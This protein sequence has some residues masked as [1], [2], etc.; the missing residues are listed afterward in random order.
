MCGIAGIY[1]FNQEAT[2]KQSLL[3]SM[4]HSL[5]HRGPDSRGIFT[6]GAFGFGMTRLKII[7]LETGN[8]PI[9]NDDKSVG[10]IFNGEI[11]NFREIKKELESHGYSF[12][13]KSDT[14]LILRAYEAYGLKCLDYF[15]GMFAVAIWN[16]HEKKLFL[17]RDRVGQKPLYYYQDRHR[18]IFASEIK[19]ILCCPDVEREIDLVALDDYLN[20]GYIPGQRTIYKHIRKLQPAHWA[21]LD[22][23][24]KLT[25]N[26]YWEFPKPKAG[27]HSSVEANIEELAC[28]LEDAVRIRLISDVPLG[29]FLS[30]GLDSSTIVS[31][32]S[33]LMPQSAKTFHIGFFE[34][35]FDES[36]Y[37][38]HVASLFNTEHHEDK[39]SCDLGDT[40]EH[41]IKCFDEPF[42]DSSAIP[43]YYLAQMASKEVT[44][45]LS[46]D[47]GDEIFGG[48]SRYIG[49]RWVKMYLKMPSL[50]RNSVNKIM[51]QI[52]EGT[53][54]RPVSLL[55]QVKWLIRTA[56]RKR[57]N[58][59]DMSIGI[60]HDHE[61]KKILHPC[62]QNAL[63]Q[64]KGAEYLS[65][66]DKIASNYGDGDVISQMMW[67]DAQTYLVDNILVKVDRMSM[68][69]SLEVRNPLLDHR[70][71]EFMAEVPV[72]LKVRGTKTKYLIKR[73][74]Q[75]ILPD[76][77]I[78][79]KKYGFSAPL[80]KWF[81]G[82]LRSMVSDLLLQNH[83]S[84]WLDAESVRS[85]VKHHFE[86]RYDYSSQIWT[87]LVLTL[88]ERNSR[89]HSRQ[90]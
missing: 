56:E 16:L 64:N 73:Y 28:L 15:Q 67:V 6:E 83:G 34:E 30:G 41:I 44:V 85:I 36:R 68:A 54:N 84:S 75:S 11:Y 31:V 29:A 79:R 69:H 47:G 42:A 80:G 27:K 88:W 89:Y 87:L 86:G 74:A 45:A 76:S 55:K 82:P 26:P 14:E 39:I 2:V 8:Q 33:Q 17:A 51:E 77:I 13:T 24:G 40:I 35:S 81:R 61:R 66:I 48:Y 59:S 7:D 12:K 37:A 72:D 38:R 22:A 20:Y 57:Q 43:T 58:P 60:F 1:L 71:I 9:F 3:D 32:M 19:A 46:G 21:T 49:Q 78:H 53:E 5:H 65:F 52:P 62:V 70:L 63:A 25:V 4:C 23:Y 10:I 90:R 50:F 18:F